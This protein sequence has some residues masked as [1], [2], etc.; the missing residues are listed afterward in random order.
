MEI[1]TKNIKIAMG[2]FLFII[3]IANVY[4][5]QYNNNINSPLMGTPIPE[6][7][8]DPNTGAAVF[9]YPIK[10]PPGTNGLQPGLALSY[11]SY[12]YL[13]YPELAGS[14]WSLTESYIQRDVSYSPE[15]TSDDK[16]ILILNGGQHKLVYDSSDGRYHTK[17]ESYMSI[18]K[19]TGGN[20]DYNEYWEVRTG[21]G[22][23]YNF[24][25]NTESEQSSLLHDYVVRWYLD[26]IKDSHENKIYYSYKENWFGEVG[27]T[28]LQR[29][30]YN[31][32]KGRK[33]D[34]SYTQMP[35]SWIVYNNGQ[36]TRRVGYLNAISIY[37][38][39]KVRSY[40]IEYTRN[41]AETRN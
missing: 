39:K 40:S 24:G 8:T 27:T 30:E 3:L 29:I 26:E 21:D 13:S 33:I 36:K 18:K 11:N 19:L 37:A 31:N 32:D 41:D 5:S 17:I 7:T 2:L 35:K 16:Y 10:V 28:Y 14:G 23:I 15:D 4:A 38:D 6:A 20:N 25:Y 12:N 34:F 1:R 22:T 9:S